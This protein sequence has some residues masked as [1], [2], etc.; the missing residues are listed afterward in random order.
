M[1]EIVEKDLGA[2]AKLVHD[3][4]GVDGYRSIER[5]K[6]LDGIVDTGEALKAAF[7]KGLSK[8]DMKVLF[9]EMDRKLST[10]TNRYYKETKNLFA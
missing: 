5:I 1:R 9:S 4:L 3:V 10:S 2:V 8:D 7:L 6:K